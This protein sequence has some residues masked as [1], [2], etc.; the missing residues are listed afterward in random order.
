M[1]RG[2]TRLGSIAVEFQ[3]HFDWRGRML[4][5]R[6]A[7]DSVIHCHLFMMYTRNLKTDCK[8][9]RVLLYNT[10]YKH[11]NYPPLTEV[12]LFIT[13]VLLRF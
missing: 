6:F 8:H 9:N 4:L 11:K 7:K 12:A 1:G 13:Q 2:A 3:K 10:S 5:R